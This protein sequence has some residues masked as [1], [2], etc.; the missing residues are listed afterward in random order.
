MA[1]AVP[2][3]R[4]HRD[5]VRVLP[6]LLRLR[7]HRR[8]H[9]VRQPPAQ[10]A[11]RRPEALF[12]GQRFW[13]LGPFLSSGIPDAAR[14]SKERG[15]PMTEERPGTATV[16]LPAEYPKEL[17]GDATLKD[18]TV[19]HLR[20]I[21]PDDAPGLVALFRPAEPAHRLPAVLRRAP[22][23]CRRPTRKSSPTWTIGSVS[24]SSRSWPGQPA[25][26]S[27]G[28]A[29]TGLADYARQDAR[30]RALV[31]GSRLRGAGRVARAGARHHPVGRGA[32][33]GGGA[34]REAVPRASCSRTTAACSGLLARRTEITG[35]K[36]EEGVVSVEF[37][38]R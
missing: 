34:R 29:A 21:R 6:R 38:P 8:R 23:G 3:L 10:Q 7:P 28:W 30:G 24:P 33:G 4:P 15:E 18:G 12:P 14:A 31:R 32:A 22:G 13:P 1:G 36:L 2:R 11:P 25:S 9:Q 5:P 27:S 37:R 16:T 17:E 26:S 19:I 35:R 20:P